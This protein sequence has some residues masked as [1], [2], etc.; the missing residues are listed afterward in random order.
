MTFRAGSH[1]YS[2]DTSTIATTSH[3]YRHFYGK[4]NLYL[5]PEIF[6]IQTYCSFL[7]Q[8]KMYFKDKG[9]NYIFLSQKVNKYMKLN[10]NNSISVQISV[11]LLVYYAFKKDPFWYALLRWHCWL[12]LKPGGG[13]VNQVWFGWGRATETWKVDPFLYQ[14]LLKNETHINTR[15]TNLTQ[16]FPTISHHFP[17]LLSFQANFGNFGIRLMKLVLFLRQF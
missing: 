14:I 16:N 15:A 9:Q 17:K 6:W 1:L 10:N 5:F 11:E 8:S 4:L 12:S 3:H 2:L 7:C 13:G